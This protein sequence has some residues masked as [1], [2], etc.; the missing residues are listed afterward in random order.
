V[1]NIFS[2]V[3]VTK[4]QKDFS[5]LKIIFSLILDVTLLIISAFQ[6]FWYYSKLGKLM[7][8]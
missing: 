4:Y 1:T 5:I 8:I 7:Y 2:L 6:T 3:F